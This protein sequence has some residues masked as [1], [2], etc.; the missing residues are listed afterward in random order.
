MKN[1]I[2]EYTSKS[3][4]DSCDNLKC[5]SLS[6]RWINKKILPVEDGDLHI[7]FIFIVKGNHC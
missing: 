6:Q 4:P 3:I 5:K 2:N 1:G 7:G